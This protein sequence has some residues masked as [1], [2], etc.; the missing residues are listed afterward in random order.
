M[1]MQGTI[2]KK[3]KVGAL[4]LP[5]FTLT[6][7]LLQSRQGSAGIRIGIIYH[8]I[9]FGVKLLLDKDAKPIQLGNN[10]TFNK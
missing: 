5:D 9:D 8:E 7:K 10:S 6:T 4:T 1:E 3:N 2:L